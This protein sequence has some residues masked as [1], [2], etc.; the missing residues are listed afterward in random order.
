MSALLQLSAVSFPTNDI[1]DTES[2]QA[3]PSFWFTMAI[4]ALLLLLGAATLIRSL[5]RSGHQIAGSFD[6]IVLQILVPKERKSEG[7]EGKIGE[8][9]RLELRKRNRRG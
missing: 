7:Q 3:D 2:L 4:A 6:R 8:D 5:W 9:D 1:Y